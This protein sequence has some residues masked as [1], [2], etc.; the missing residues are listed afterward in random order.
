VNF[1]AIPPRARFPV[2]VTIGAYQFGK[3]TEP[4]FQS[5]GP[6]LREFFIENP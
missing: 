1:T 5:T 3:T 6:V 4:K 2:K